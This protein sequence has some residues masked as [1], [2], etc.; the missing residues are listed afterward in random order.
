[1]PIPIVKI[2]Q[3]YRGR[4]S[5]TPV[6]YNLHKSAWENRN[7][8]DACYRE[9]RLHSRRGENVIARLRLTNILKAIKSNPIRIRFKC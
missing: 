6:T 4:I 5:Y 7:V 3:P 2:V 8:T 9:A 1:M